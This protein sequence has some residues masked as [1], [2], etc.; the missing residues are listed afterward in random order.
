MASRGL[1]GLSALPPP[2]RPRGV[3]GG[4]ADVS[5]RPAWYSVHQDVYHDMQECTEGNNIEPWNVRPGTGGRPRCQRCT[6]LS[7]RSDA[8]IAALEDGLPR[9]VFR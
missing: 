9:G 5:V 4:L 1:L 2:P 7:H 8:L 3:L 6:Q